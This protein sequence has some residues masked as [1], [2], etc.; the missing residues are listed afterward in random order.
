MWNWA[1][2][3]GNSRALAARKRALL[4]RT[5]WP[6]APR[7]RASCPAK[8]LRELATHTL[9]PR[10]LPATTLQVA[11]G[12]LQ[13]ALRVLRTRA[14]CS[15]KRGQFALKKWANALKK[16]GNCHWGIAHF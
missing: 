7:K 3:R 11:R 1:D 16:E 13:L 12:A 2:F 4:A 10:H 14:S 5:E 9:A 8:R 6:V 15:Q